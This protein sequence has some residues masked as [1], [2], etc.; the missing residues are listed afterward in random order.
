M[1]ES[2]PLHVCKEGSPMPNAHHPI[3]RW[4]HVEAKCIDTDDLGSLYLC[5]ACGTTWRVDLPKE[6]R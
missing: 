1:I 5:P 4:M 3:Q 6:A 2:D